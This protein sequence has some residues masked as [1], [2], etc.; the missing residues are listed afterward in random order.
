MLI[1]GK[2]MTVTEIAAELEISLTATSN[3]LTILKDLDV[4]E[5]HG[6]EGHVFYFVNTDMPDDFRRIIAVA[7]RK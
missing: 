7:V 2:H 1:S 3:H 5:A 4:L 6:T